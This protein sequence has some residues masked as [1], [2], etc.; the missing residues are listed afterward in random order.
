MVAAVSVFGQEEPLPAD[1]PG[2]A[3][4][5]PLVVLAVEPARE[6]PEPTLAGAARANDY[7]SFDALFRGSPADAYRPLHDLWTYSVTD[8]IGAFYGPEMFER[9]ARAYPQFAESIAQYRI[10]DSRGNVF[11][12]SS[13]TR[14]FLLARAESGALASQPIGSQPTGLSA[15]ASPAP[16]GLRASRSTRRKPEATIAAVAPVPQPARTPQPVPAPAPVAIVA[17]V[18]VVIRPEPVPAVAAPPAAS[19]TDSHGSA[20]GLLLLIIGLIGTGVLALIV[21]AP[22]EVPSP[23]VTPRR[24]P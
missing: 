10:V 4:V 14:A 13:E 18:P 22:R 11:Y 1:S 16:G 2:V 15:K 12:P 19:A 7:A 20:R 6:F 21:R 3:A 8:P 17:E 9:F 5:E 24:D 23:S